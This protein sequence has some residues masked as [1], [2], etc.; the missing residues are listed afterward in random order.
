M[1]EGGR[2]ELKPG[3]YIQLV[4]LGN[5]GIPFCTIRPA[6]P[7]RKVDYYNGAVGEWFDVKYKSPSFS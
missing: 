1:Y 2:F 4:F 5:L 7:S 3:R 6:F